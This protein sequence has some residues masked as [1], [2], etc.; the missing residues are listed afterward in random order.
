[1]KATIT[2]FMLTAVL[3]GENATV[4]KI[5]KYYDNFLLEEVGKFTKYYDRMI[6]KSEDKSLEKIGFIAK[7]RQLNF[8]LEKLLNGE[9]IVEENQ[10]AETME[11]VPEPI[12]VADEKIKAETEKIVW[13]SPENAADDYIIPIPDP[14]LKS[15]IYK[16]MNKELTEKLTFAEA[17]KIK[18][19]MLSSYSYKTRKYDQNEIYDIKPLQYFV[20]LED[21][22]VFKNQISDMS[23]L[24]GLIKLKKLNLR[25]NKLTNFTFIANLKELIELD[26]LENTVPNL[27]FLHTFTKLESL[28]LNDLVDGNLSYLKSCKQLQSINIVDSTITEID[29]LKGLSNINFLYLSWQKNIKKFDAISSFHKLKTLSHKV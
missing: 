25:N 8:T 14:V 21:L 16:A 7:K 13:T 27:E 15:R 26:L 6:E 3:L 2:F 23:V 12:N 11:E 24:K 29:S 9:E 28:N 10:I 17:K 18:K 1:M 20:N 22:N 4:D 5:N 19:L